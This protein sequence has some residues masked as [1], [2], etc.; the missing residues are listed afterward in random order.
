MIWGTKAQRLIGSIVAKVNIRAFYWENKNGVE[1]LSSFIVIN[2]T[3][4]NILASIAM[5]NNS[6]KDVQEQKF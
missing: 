4:T 3:Y 2:S 5:G 1:G 6:N